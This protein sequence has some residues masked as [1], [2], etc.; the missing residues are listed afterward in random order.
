MKM[1]VRPTTTT[2]TCPPDYEGFGIGAAVSSSK[3]NDA[4]NG[5]YVSDNNVVRNYI[6]TG[7][8][9]ETDT[10]GLKYDANNLY[11]AAQ[12]TQTDNATRVGSLGWA[13]KA[14]NFE[15]VAQ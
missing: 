11:L 13:N 14:Q 15:A 5:N 8:R 6:G 4:Q 1:V 2:K 3:R 10:G 9:A 7:D 12:Y